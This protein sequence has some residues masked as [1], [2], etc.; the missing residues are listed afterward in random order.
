[1][2]RVPSFRFPSICLSTLFAAMA[3]AA[4]QGFFF[5]TT[6]TEHTLSLSGGTPLQDLHSNEVA[7][8]DFGSCLTYSA[9][10]W[11]A[12][13]CYQTMA[14][15]ENGDG[16]FWNPALFGDIDAL[17]HLYL[18]GQVPS[19]RTVF[20][21]P[22]VAM[23]TTRSGAPGL[24]P[25]DTGRIL[26][27]GGQYGQ[28]HYFLSA[29]QVQS[30][31]GIPITP[32]VVDVDAITADQSLGIFFSLD[33]DLVVN[34]TCG[35]TFVRDGDVLMI[36][37]TA[38]TWSPDGRAVLV[39]PGCALVVY[40]EAQMD[41]FVWNANVSD[42]NGNCVSVVQD[43]E[44]LDIHVT[45]RRTPMT[46]CSGTFTIPSFFFSG[47]LLTGAGVLTTENGGQAGNN[48]CGPL[49]RTCG[50]GPT[51]GDQMGL[52][53]PTPAAGISSYINALD[54]VFFTKLFL[55]EP[56]QPVVIAPAPVVL[57]VNTPHAFTLMAVEV[58][59]P[60]VAP[61]GP[62][63]PFLFFNDLYILGSP[64]WTTF[65]FNPGIITITTPVVPSAARLV[66]QAGTIFGSS[67]DLS[68]PATVEVL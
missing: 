53:P 54:T 32:I 13:S 26:Q 45:G 44:A 33:Q 43:L 59:P 28:V 25:G 61:H 30:V 27:L 22:S 64:P 46:F 62:L 56:A 36:P 14:G 39:T 29:E 67:I 38:I 57:H 51:L 4:A 41:A 11:G 21:S 35:T 40:T 6:Q 60:T 65:W 66:F 52:R 49:A 50:F 8:V 37:P 42:A 19:P 2:H 5:S 63:P 68:A 47:E 7:H 17:V 10:K 58:V 12:R 16:M 20:W 31:L 1:M 24:R 15:D 18:P 3:P 48:G 23:G 34:T 9:E 55:I